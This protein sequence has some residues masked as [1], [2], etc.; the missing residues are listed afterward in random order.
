MR[1]YVDVPAADFQRAVSKDA[2]PVE[3]AVQNA[4]HKNSPV[5]QRSAS[6]FDTLQNRVMEAGTRTR[7]GS[8]NSTRNRRADRCSRPGFQRQNRRSRFLTARGLVKPA[9]R[10]NHA[11][12]FVSSSAS[13]PPHRP[14]EDRQ[15]AIPSADKENPVLSSLSPVLIHP[16]RPGSVAAVPAPLSS[17]VPPRPG[18]PRGQNCQTPHTVPLRAQRSR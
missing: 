5:L 2:S 6:S 18:D 9:G 8:R 1:H 16:T 15:A 12:Q 13:R 14:A 11:G 17:H 7:N 3:E 10:H 4:P